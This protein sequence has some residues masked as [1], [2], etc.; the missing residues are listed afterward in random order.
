MSYAPPPEWQE[1][2]EQAAAQPA[3]AAPQYSPDG[4][5]YWDGQQWRPVAAPGPLWARPYGPPESRA[6]A[7]VALVALAIAG[8]ALFTVGEGLDLLA[9]LVAPDSIVEAVGAGFQIV[10]FLASLAGLVGSAIAVPMWMHRAFRNLPALGARDLR[11]SP[12]WAAG[13]WFIP[14]AN[15]V[16]P[17]LVTR[18]LWIR[19][20]GEPAPVWPLLPAWW[21][22]WVGA[23]IL[24]VGSNLAGRFSRIG[25]D[26]LGILNDVGLVLAGVL[27]IL[28]VQRITRRQRTRHAQL[29]SA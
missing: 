12:A 25:G 24:Q 29:V 7:A 17:Y 23:Y 16:I 15:L 22:A 10:A 20:G 14:L 4:R 3:R 8:A 1:R 18:E 6:A 26:A 2:Q 21:V 27:L 9:A 13:G 19:A 28:V 11:W 5:W